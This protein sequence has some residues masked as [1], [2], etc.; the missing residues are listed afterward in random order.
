MLSF[1][2]SLLVDCFRKETPT[3]YHSS[4][5]EKSALQRRVEAQLDHCCLCRGSGHISANCTWSK[6]N[7]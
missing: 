1:A 3:Y 2:W 5:L 4:G 7:A 6:E